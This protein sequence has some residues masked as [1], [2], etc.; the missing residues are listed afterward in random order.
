MADGF[1]AGNRRKALFSTGQ[2]TVR[3]KIYY[4]C[5]QRAGRGFNLL[6]EAASKLSRDGILPDIPNNSGYRS[7][8]DRTS[9]FMGVDR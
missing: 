3:P 4:S 7:K 2:N 6:V 8:V 5:G 9:N 1:L